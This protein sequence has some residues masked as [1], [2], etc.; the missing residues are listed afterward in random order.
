MNAEIR[1]LLLTA[2][3][4]ERIL[5][6]GAEPFITTPD[7]FRKLFLTEVAKWTALVRYAK[8]KLE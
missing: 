7:E 5:E 4:K 1:K 6:R 2:D 3:V 8:I